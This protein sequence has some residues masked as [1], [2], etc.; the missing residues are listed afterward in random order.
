[1]QMQE[2]VNLIPNCSEATFRIDISN[3]SKDEIEKI[4][5]IW[6]HNVKEKMKE[7]GDEDGEYDGSEL[8]ETAIF[9]KKLLQADGDFPYNC[10][11]TVDHIV[12]AAE[13]ALGKKLK[14]ETESR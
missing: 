14:T 10:S 1:M 9:D 12:A 8:V 4:K 5:I 2:E 6:E 13:K 7:D 3:L 11:D